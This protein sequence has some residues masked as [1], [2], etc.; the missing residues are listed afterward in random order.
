MK[1]ILFFLALA[2][3]PS[4]QAQQAVDAAEHLTERLIA[5]LSSLDSSFS[6]GT[7]QGTKVY[8]AQLEC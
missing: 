7:E 2:V 3:S 1:S 5:M 8:G 6:S 4:V